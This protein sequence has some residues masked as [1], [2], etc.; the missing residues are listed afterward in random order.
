M[1]LLTLLDASHSTYFTVHSE[2]GVD[3][4]AILKGSGSFYAPVLV[5]NK[6]KVIIETTLPNG[7]D[8]LIDFSFVSVGGV[9]LTMEIYGINGFKYFWN[10]VWCLRF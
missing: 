2:S 8:D 3:A 9:T 5:N 10:Q 4:S 1:C 6:A 7:V